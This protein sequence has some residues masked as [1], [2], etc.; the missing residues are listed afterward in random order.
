MSALKDGRWGLVA[1]QGLLFA[2][3]AVTA[4]MPA[5]TPAWAPLLWQSL[6]T[7]LA[8]VVVGS[9]GVIWS[10]KD[11]GESLTPSPVP[12][13]AGLVA[14]GPYHYARHP[15]YTALVVIC[16][17]VAV[18]SGAT[19]TYLSVLLLA[20][21]F[22]YKTRVEERYLLAAYDGYAEYAQRTGKFIPGVGQLVASL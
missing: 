1:V 12:N 4:L 11:L 3:V 6:W 19:L 2:A 21:F 10:A 16:L 17:G 8:L 20:L 22:E 9:I 18:G 7:G 15:M 14:R 5:L 13:R